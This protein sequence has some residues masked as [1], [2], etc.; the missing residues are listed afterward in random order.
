[1]H[2][3]ILTIGSRGDVQPFIALGL[4]LKQAGHQVNLATYSNFKDLV[5]S[6]GLDFSA[7]GGDGQAFMLEE[8]GQKILDAGGNPF[9]FI[10][11]YAKA[12]EPFFEEVLVNSWHACQGTDAIIAHGTAFW[13]YDIA[14]KLEIPIYMAG[15]Q[16]SFPNREFPHPMMPPTL[17]LGG[18]INP[19][20]YVLFWRLF[21]QPFR[22]PI[23]QWRVNTLNLPTWRQHPLGDKVW[24]QVPILYGYS[25]S[26][27]PKPTNWPEHLHVTG[28]WFLDS[29]PDFLPP[30]ELVD[31]LEAGDPPVYIGFGSMTGRNPELITEIALAAL[32]QTGQRGILLTGW[33]GIRPKDLPDSVFK[34]ESIPH[35]WLFP[36]MAAIVHHGGAGTTAAALRSGVPTIVVPFFA[37]QPFWGHWT[38][39]LGVGPQ[40]IP[41]KKLTVEKLAATI[42]TAVEDEAM[43]KRAAILAQKIRSEDGAAQA[44]KAFHQHLSPE[45]NS[46]QQLSFQL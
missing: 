8:A 44:V 11:R 21:Q 30:P 15:L 45:L 13:G 27:I 32:K 14:E 16:P 29:P 18:L 46:F 5:G 33:G 25:P 10:H 31:F 19:L 43:G 40:P 6:Y 26:V 28:Y 17:P 1:M 20:T 35:D 38:A 7:V 41:K 3:T 42:R 9:S 39:Q 22:Q 2:V 4:G 23:D 12:L 37:D 36:Q 34:L 24:R